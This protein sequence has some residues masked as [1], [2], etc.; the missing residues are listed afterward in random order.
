MTI[1]T[2][3]T[4]GDIVYI[5]IGL[6]IKKAIIDGVY[7]CDDNLQE[8][9]IRYNLSFQDSCGKTKNISLYEDEVFK[10]PGELLEKLKKSIPTTNN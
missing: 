10:T 5:L 9:I 1:E 7:F 8:K 6:E 2:K 3:G 4:R